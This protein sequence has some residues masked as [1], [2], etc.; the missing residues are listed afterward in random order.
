MPK[1]ISQ[2]VHMQ[3]KLRYN[4]RARKFASNEYTTWDKVDV[5]RVLAHDIPDS[6]LGKEIGRSIQAIQMKRAREYTKWNCKKFESAGEI[7]GG[8]ETWIG[9][10]WQAALLYLH[11]WFTLITGGY[12]R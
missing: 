5:E 12:N 10:V 1:H 3:Q 6:Q 11:R 2:E 8:H 9:T 4:A 7:Y